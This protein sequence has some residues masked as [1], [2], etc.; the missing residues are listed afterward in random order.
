MKYAFLL[1]YFTKKKL[2]LT[3]W[4]TRESVSVFSTSTSCLSQNCNS[5][6]R[7]YKLQFSVETFFGSKFSKLEKKKALQEKLLAD[8]K[9]PLIVSAI[10]LFCEVN[11]FHLRRKKK[12]L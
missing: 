10:P 5:N 3:S 1:S 2:L 7:R 6:T 4:R 9:D 8:F 12:H 11:G